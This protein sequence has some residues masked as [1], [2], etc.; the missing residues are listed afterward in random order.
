M[1]SLCSRLGHAAFPVTRDRSQGGY[2]ELKQCPVCKNT[3]GGSFRYESDGLQGWFDCDVCG[4][5]TMSAELFIQLQD[6]VLDVGHWELT[7]MQRAVL[8]HRIRTQSLASQGDQ[9]EMFRITPEVSDRIRAGEVL[10]SPSVQAAN[11]VRF[12]GDTESESGMPISRFPVEL[13]AII[14]TF[15]R[16]KA[17]QLALELKEKEVVRTHGPDTWF[18]QADGSKPVLT[19]PTKISLSLAGWEEYESERRGQFAGKD[20]FLALQFG[21]PDLDAFVNDVLKP[22]IEEN[23]GC[24]LS[25][26]RDVSR[27][28][29]IDNIMRVRIRDARFV[30]ADLTH[31]NRGVYWEAGFAEGLGKPVI[32]T[33]EER[34]FEQDKTHFDTNHCTTVTWSAD[35]P[36][37]FEKELIATIRRSLEE[38]Q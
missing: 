35:D 20:G 6:G 28:G 18:P 17:M 14:G 16:D 23:L 8:S 32:Y 4:R 37:G 24:K 1:S 11:L 38:R 7:P 33:C 36:E 31:D 12:I 13:H 27:A 26:M 19:E 9:N 29:V 15:D 5:Y 3:E 2:E 22:A 30:I 10:P 34:K 21:K 25:D